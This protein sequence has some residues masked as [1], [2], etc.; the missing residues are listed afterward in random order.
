MWLS[1]DIE[2][3]VYNC[4]QPP[5]I[6]LWP[7][8][9][10]A[11][12]WER[13]HIDLHVPWLHVPSSGEQSFEMARSNSHE[14]ITTAWENW[15]LCLPGMACLVNW[16]GLSSLLWSSRS[17]LMTLSVWKVPHIPNREA[18]WFLQTFKHS[19]YTSWKKWTVH[20]LEIGNVSAYIYLATPNGM[21]PS[22]LYSNHKPYMHA[23]MLKPS[24]KEHEYNILIIEVTVWDSLCFLG[25]WGLD[26]SGC[27]H[28]AACYKVEVTS[29]V[30]I[31][32]SYTSLVGV[33]HGGEHCTRIIIMTSHW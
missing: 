16:M 10:P 30:L 18:E 14:D 20:A 19:L 13:V 27:N 12:P 31:S 33:S 2:N 24:V 6:P 25:T 23:Y 11:A 7:W 21:A 15:C 32:Y 22:E 9:L 3:T 26:Q 5:T 8:P 29:S 4:K 17:V 28:K 1:S